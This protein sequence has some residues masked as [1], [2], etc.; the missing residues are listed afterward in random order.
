MM[1]FRATTVRTCPGAVCRWPNFSLAFA[2]LLIVLA[3]SLGVATQVQAQAPTGIALSVS[4]NEVGEG[5]TATTVTV[6][7]TLDGTGTLSNPTTVTVR[8]GASSI[9][10]GGTED[11]FPLGDTA[12]EGTDYQTIQHFDLTIPAN[13]RSGAGTFTLTPIQD[14]VAEGDE[15]IT[16]AGTVDGFTVTGTELTLKDDETAPTE[17]TLTV[18]PDEVAENDNGTIVTVTATLQG[19]ATLPGATRVSVQI[20]ASSDG[21]TEGTD[22]LS[23]SDFELTIPGE[24]SSVT[25]RFRLT[26]KQDTVAEGDETISVLG[27]AIGFTVTGTEVT[28]ADDETSPAAITLSVSPDTVREDDTTGTTGTVT[29]SLEGR[30]TRSVATTVTV[31]IGASGDSAMEGMDYVEVSDFTVTIPGGMLSGTETFTL[32]PSQDSMA[33]GDETISALGTANGFTVTG[34][35]VIIEDDEPTGIALSLLPTKIAEDQRTTSV[36]VTAALDGSETSA[37][38]ITVTVKVGASGDSATEGTDYASVR[39]FTVTIPAN[40]MS[41]RSAFFFLSTNDTDVEGNETISVTGSAEGHTITGTTLTLVDDDGPTLTLSVTSTIVNEGNSSEVTAEL[42]S[43]WTQPVTA[44]VVVALGTNAIADHVTLAGAT[45]TIPAGQTRST[46]SA[47]ITATDDDLYDENRVVYLRIG[48]LTAGVTAPLDPVKITIIEDE[49]IP[50]LSLSGDAPSIRED[51]GTVSVNA[52]LDVKLRNP[53]TATL[54]VFEVSERSSVDDVSLSETTL[55]FEAG[56]TMSAN[57]V[58]ITGVNNAVYDFYQRVRVA[59]ERV[60]GGSVSRVNDVVLRIIDDE[61]V[62]SVT[63]SGPTSIGEN[64]GTS[65]VTGTMDV[66]ANYSIAVDVRVGPL[67]TAS[68]NDYTLTGTTLTFAAVT[69]TTADQVTLTANDNEFYSGDKRVRLF[70]S[71]GDQVQLPERF[72]V[73]IVDDEATPTVTLGVDTNAIDEN[74]GVA[75]VT[76]SLDV[77]AEHSIEVEIVVLPLS[78]EDLAPAD[79][80]DFTLSGAMITIQPKM[81][82]TTDSAMI[83]AANNN[84][85]E[86]DKKIEV[87]AQLSGTN[88]VQAFPV[89]TILE[90]DTQPAGIRLTVAP[91][92]VAESAAA[93][94]VTVTATLAGTVT[95]PEATPVMVSVGGPGDEATEGTD[96]ETVDDLTVTIPGGMLSGTGTFT[97]MPVQDNIAEGAETISVTSMTPDFAIINALMLLTDDET[98]P[99]AITLSVSPDEVRENDPATTVTVTATL[100]GTVTLPDATAVTVS[101]GGSGDGATEGTDYE[102]VDDLSVTI[103]GEMLS[104]TGR[105]TLTPVLDEVPEGTETIS[106]E[107]EATGFDVTDTEVTLAD[108]TAPGAANSAVATAEDT[109]YTFQATDFGFT[110]GDGDALVSVEVTTVPGAGSLTLN[111]AAVNAADTVTKAQL[112]GGELEFTPVADANGAGY[113]SFTF[114]VSDGTDESA[115]ATMTINVTAVNDAPTGAPTITGAA[116]V[117]QTL[118]ASRTGIGDVDGLPANESDYAYQWVRVDTDATEADITGATSRTYEVAAADEGKKL[119][120]EVSY[121]DGDGTPE[122]VPSAETATVGS[123]TAPGAA[124]SAVTTAEDTSYTFQATDFGFT[125]G[126]GDALAL[127]EVTTVPGAGSLTLNSAAVNAADTVTKA[128]LDGGELAFAP[129]ADANGAGYASFTFKVSDGTDESAAATMTINV[130]A[131]NDAP[132]GAPT[133]TGTARVGQTLSASRTGIG[134][135]DG[136]PANE[137][138]YAYQWVRVDG[139]TSTDITGATSRTYEVASA[140]E[141]K[142]LKVEVSYTD[143]DGMPETV[144]SAETATVG[145]NT[146]PGAANSA[147]TTDEDTAYTFAA[148]DFEFTDDDGDALVSVEV[149][150]VPGAGSLTLNSAAVNA[151]DT[152]TKAQLDGGEL[153]FTPVADA[154]GAG[155]ASFTFKVSD[156]TDESAAAT[157]TINVTAVNDA[158]TGAPTITGT[159]RVGQTLS[160][161]RTGIGDVDGLPANESD[162]AYQWVRVDTDATEADITGA[163][164]RTYE[165]AAADEGKKLKVEVSYTDGDG[166]PETV[167]SAETATVG[168][169]TA[170]VAANSAVTTAEDTSYT[171]QATDFEFTD[172]DGDALVSVEVTTVPGAGSL[173]L[174]SAAVNVKDTVTKAQ[175]DGGELAF[176]P[177]ADANGAGYASFTF[178]VS[179][180]TDESAAATMTINVTAVND[181]PTGAPTIT[182]T[183]RVGQTLSASRTGIGDVDGLPANESDYAYQWVRVDGGTSTDITGATSRTYEVASADEGKKLKVEVSYTDGDGM[184]ETVPSA[185]TATV[186]SNTAPGAANSAVA[187]AEDTSYTFQATDFG[188]TDGDGDA[189]VSVEVTTVPGAG[190]LTLNSAAVN[191]ADTVTKAQLDGGELEFTPVADA[192]GAGYASFTFKVSDGTDESAAATMTINVTAVNDAPT[193]A[194]TITGA[195]RVGQTLSASRTGIG[196]VDGLPANESDYA[197]QWVRVDGGTSTDITGATS[198]TYEVAAADEGKKLKV[199]V[200]YTDGDGTPETVPSAETATVGSNTAPGAANSAVTTAEDTSYTF[201]ATDFGFTDGDGDALALVEVTTVPGAGSLTLNSAAVNAAD[202][203]TKAQLD[204]GELA[205]APVADANGAGYASFTFKVSDGTDES[206]AATMTINVTAVNDAPT[207]APTIT[208]T[209]RVGQTLSASRTGIGDVDGLPANESDYAY[210]WVRVDT[211]ATEAN[212]TGATSRTYEVASADEGKKLKVEVSYT[213][214]DGMPETV[215][216]AETATVGSNTAPGAANSAVTTDEDTAYTFA[217]TDFEFTDDDGDAL[218]SVEVTTVPGAGSLTLNSAAVNAADTVT[219]AQLD[220]GELEFT[221]VAD[222]NGAGYASFT[223]KVSDGTDESAAATMAINVTAVNDAPTGAPTITGTARVGQT[224]SASRTGIGDVDGLP[225][226]ESDYAYQWVRV[227]TDATEA[228]ITGATSRTYEVAAAD[229]G[230]KLK[231]EVS[232]TDGDGTPETVPSAETATVGSNT[233]PGAANSAVTTAEDTSYTFQ[234]TDFGFTDGDGDAL[235]LVEVTTVPGAGSLTLNSA[236]VNAADTVTKAQLDGGELAFAPV[237]DANGAGYASFTFKVSDGTDESA[238]ATMTINVTAVNDAPTGAPTITGTARVGQTLSASRTGIGDVDGLPANESDYAYQWVR[239]DDGGRR[240]TSRGRRRARTRWRRRTRARSSRWR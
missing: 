107:G 80:D 72:F 1:R 96:Y 21:A 239:V 150:T 189:L 168:S 34:T 75:I 53:I 220:G 40:S 190:S 153:E 33:E 31:Q 22:Y 201:Q 89:V 92:A 3:A 222:A 149:T 36:T 219:K 103:P 146:A 236:A 152:V 194:P 110:D 176:A 41:A 70:Q 159:A 87:A 50:R 86:G 240:R 134:D 47:T 199:E 8:I 140:D 166:M 206:A 195:A 232:Y 32:T 12:T 9:V 193:G 229:E 196:D 214:G 48:S 49:S 61:P 29:A 148:T 120:V 142:K 237:A 20:G 187:T 113:A 56:R 129:V 161:S 188:F 46:S 118:S 23:I 171:F 136:L 179:D 178:K 104:G 59:V 200:S 226:N 202:T 35:Q 30:V 18:S 37:E 130:T 234:A 157:M 147:V 223:F 28:L 135:V 106:V 204:G 167:P 210:Q 17:I 54:K 73:T 225:A 158:P 123:N 181:A 97:L 95:L 155:Y 83:T 177:V 172:D 65:T 163:T 52:S 224:L 191:A 45:L 55:R 102:T 215:P 5:D 162:Y 173:M 125:D 93:T 112:D 160:A 211:D 216:S 116:R 132:T 213:D 138:D 100:A 42:D 14:T 235:A 164:S 231:V 78:P 127:V 98:A 197:Y 60:D 218:V 74:G 39:D 77:A 203:V 230:K 233:A 170:P 227:D 122:T 26:P 76:A 11:I 121:T 2:G 228:D 79:A 13:A 144:P 145:S 99:T 115:A 119:K 101:V 184:P 205:F 133:I 141:G 192:N 207:G 25:G 131:V 84:V 165:V 183:A 90:D 143:G 209:A 151:A 24:E 180:G 85:Y 71:S 43:A 126:D 58:T 105:F 198:R 185:E 10:I 137:S 57:S 169:N 154:N 82:T 139:A 94:M 62:P 63:L 212:I 19:S 51:G 111:S 6:T 88:L 108:N 124:N 221:P 182:G 109:S 38:A 175:L 68:E 117:G 114:K 44:T 91:P 69:T 67:Q 15:T 217:A 81:K 186:G 208:G 16:V 66:P 7:A 64:G 238:A 27:T 128:Q 4:P 174:N 156:G